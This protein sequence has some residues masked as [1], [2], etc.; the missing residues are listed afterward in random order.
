MDSG[1]RELTL[2]QRDEGGLS[3][4]AEYHK[5]GSHGAGFFEY[6]EEKKM[7]NLEEK[8]LAH[9]H[10]S[11]DERSHAGGTRSRASSFAPGSLKMDHLG[12]IDR[13]ASAIEDQAKQDGV[14]RSQAWLHASVLKPHLTTEEESDVVAELQA[15]HTQAAPPLTAELKE[16]YASFQRCLDLRDKYMSASL[17]TLGD[18]PRD[19]DGVFIKPPPADSNLRPSDPGATPR[20]ATIDSPQFEP[21]KIYPPPPPPH[22]KFKAHNTKA[23]EVTHAPEDGDVPFKFSECE[24]PAAGPWEWEMDEKGVFQV[25]Q[26]ATAPDRKPLFNV[27]TIKDFFVDLDVV[28]SVV[29]DGPAKSYAFRR[30]KYL[31][32]KWQMYSLLNEYQELADM[33]RVPHRDFYNLRKVDTHV[34]HS[35]M[36]NQKHLLRFIKHKIKHHPDDKVIVRDGK[37]LTLREVFESLNLTAYDLSIDTLDMHA[38][39]EAFQRFDKFNLK[40]NPIGEARLREIFMKTDNHIQGRYLAELTKEVMTDLEQSKY[41]NCEWRISIYGRSTAEWDKLAKW[42]VRNELFSHNVRWLIQIPRLYDVYKANKTI[43]NFSEVLRNVF[44]PLFEVTKDPSTHPELHVF[45]QRVVGIDCVDD[46]SKPERRIYRKFPYPKDW[47]TP[48]NPPYSYWMYYMFANMTSLNHWRRARGF[49]T[50]VFRPHSGEAGDTDH[51]AAAFLTAHSISHGILLRKVPALQY[52]FY[53]KQIGLAM[54]PLSNNAL[55]L[56][57]DRNPL[58]EFFKTGLNVSLSTDDPLQ[59]HFTKEPLLEEYSVAA[60]IYKLGQSGL[61]ELARNSVI[62]SGFEMGVKRHWIGQHWY[63]PGAAGND[64]NKTNVPDKR[65]AFRYDTL[66]EELRLIY[67]NKNA[68][69][70]PKTPMSNMLDTSPDAVAAHAMAPV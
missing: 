44:L 24:I 28:L 13:F 33:K 39:Q 41:Q 31:L 21:W 38:H 7:Q 26:D 14:A 62:Q 70:V 55:F 50:F 12:E 46:E 47:D 36:M 58:P 51:L 67:S 68:T 57:Y 30:L 34:H 52:L 22:W 42:I 17:Q 65:L 25:Y 29:T 66:I 49:N 2:L 60:H 53:L 37:E 18:D 35:S 64:I 27:P 45:L 11:Q 5:L 32:S 48:Q 9:Q 10:G 4:P 61:A 40:Y 23:P 20:P 69:V 8:L 54:S 6:H 16:L 1:D 59:F 19:H 63:L 3:P 43:S 56:S 15:T